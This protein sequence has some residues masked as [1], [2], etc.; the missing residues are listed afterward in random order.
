MVGMRTDSLYASSS[1]CHCRSRKRCD[2]CQSER[3]VGESEVHDDERDANENRAV[4]RQHQFF[5]FTLH[6]MQGCVSRLVLEAGIFHRRS[7]K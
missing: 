3:Q 6:A 1:Y 4:S 7:W 5:G 2:K